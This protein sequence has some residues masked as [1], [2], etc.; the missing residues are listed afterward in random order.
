MFLEE[1][2]SGTYIAD[3]CFVYKQDLFYNF[4]KKHN[5][6]AVYIAPGSQFMTYAP[7]TTDLNVHPFAGGFMTNSL[8]LFQLNSDTDKAYFHRVTENKFTLDV[9]VPDSYGSHTIQ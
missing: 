4:I 5:I 9:T 8:I 6:K 3:V 1:F 2:V 7:F